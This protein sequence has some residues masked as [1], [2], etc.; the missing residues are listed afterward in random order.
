M[1]KTLE[2]KAWL[3]PNPVLIIAAYKEDE[4]IAIMNAAWGG[5]VDNDLIGITISSNHDTTK[6]ILHKKCFTISLATKET[7]LAAD[8]VGIVSGNKEK[9]KFNLSHLTSTKSA[10]INAPIINEMPLSFECELVSYDAN[11]EYLLARVVS[12]SADSAIVDENGNID[13]RKFHPIFFNPLNNYYHEFGD[14]VGKAFKCG[15]MIKN[16]K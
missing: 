6:A 11:R 16:Q 3:T 1:R 5:V 8:Y 15:L 12:I 10:N 2:S 7:C 13:M 14:V 4:N 9:D